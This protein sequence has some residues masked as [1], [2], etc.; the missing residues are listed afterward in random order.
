MRPKESMIVKVLKAQENKPS[1][2]DW[3]RTVLN[4]INELK[5]NLTIANIQK[6]KKVQIKNR[7]KDAIKKA[8]FK[9]L[10]NEK[11]KPKSKLKD[12]KYNNLNI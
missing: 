9:Y 12:L 2:G 10:S 5:L 1:K 4:D 3:L 8:A 7:V 11:D 6:L